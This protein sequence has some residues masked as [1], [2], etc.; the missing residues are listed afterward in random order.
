M[1]TDSAGSLPVVR[2]VW[3]DRVL[4]FTARIYVMGILNVTPDSFYDGGRFDVVEKAV[5]QAE[6]MAED[7]ADIIDVCGESSRPGSDLRPRT[8]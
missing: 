8:R 1:N 2:I 7:G 5:A 4:D 3:K 6:Q